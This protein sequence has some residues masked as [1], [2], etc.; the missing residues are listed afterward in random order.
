[1][2][3]DQHFFFFFLAVGHGLWCRSGCGCVGRSVLVGGWV[4]R[5]VAGLWVGLWV[6]R[7]VH[8]GGCGC[9]LVGLVGVDLVDFFFL[10]CELWWWWLWLCVWLWLWQ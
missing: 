4:H 10:C 8:G 9:C 3:A 5:W 2:G 7:C 6:D 1:M